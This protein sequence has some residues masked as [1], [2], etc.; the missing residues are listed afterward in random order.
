MAFKESKIDPGAYNAL[1]EA[2]AAIYWNKKPWARHVRSLFSSHPELLAGLELEGSSTKMEMTSVIVDRMMRNETKYQALAIGVMTD[3]AKVRNFTNL[4]GQPD[5]DALIH[6]AEAAVQELHAW[7]VGH[8]DIANKHAART[9]EIAKAADLARQNRFFN[10]KLAGLNDEFILLSGLT[11]HHKRGKGFEVSINSVFGLYDLEPRAAYDL[12]LEQI[13]G[14][15]AFDTDGYILEAKWWK[16]PIGRDHLDVFSTKV[17]R[18]GK[19]TL[20]LMISMSGFTKDA[21]EQYSDRSPFIV[22]D[23][24]DYMHIMNG[25]V[26]LDDVLRR[27][28]QH[29]HETGHCFFS[30]RDML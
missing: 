27:K 10:D 12:K 15:F 23:G 13:D 28:K 1:I 17:G 3:V 9:A 26:R 6:K 5:A 20:G 8:Q 21:L 30:A 14:A 2:L 25:D 18:K 22:M 24:I 19:N 16:E 29:F 11:D 4:K 7:V